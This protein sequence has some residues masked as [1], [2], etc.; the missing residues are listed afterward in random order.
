MENKCISRKFQ[1]ILFIKV[2]K[3]H[4]RHT[5]F[6]E[7]LICTYVDSLETMIKDWN[8]IDLCSI[9]LL[10]NNMTKPLLFK[11]RITF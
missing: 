7:S 9:L 1:M 8:S 2:D 4:Q 6:S 3:K 10:Y 5:L 11:D